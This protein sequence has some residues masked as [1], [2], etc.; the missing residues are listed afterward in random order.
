MSDSVARPAPDDGARG[1][2]LGRVDHLRLRELLG[3]GPLG[4]VYLAVDSVAD[5]LLAVKVLPAALSGESPEADRLR[6]A[7]LPAARFSHPRLAALRHLHTA[8]EADDGARALGVTRGLLLLLSDYI[9]GQD[10]ARWLQAH[11]ADAG[12]TTALMGWFAEAA[13]ALD[14]AHAHGLAHGALSP[15]NLRIGS[16]GHAHLTDLASSAELRRSLRHLGAPVP[17]A[18]AIGEPTPAGDVHDLARLLAGALAPVPAAGAERLPLAALDAA[19]NAALAGAL[20]ADPSRRPGSCRALVEACRAGLVPTAVA[21]VPAAPMAAPTADALPA[22]AP[23]PATAA[24][25]RPAVVSPPRVPSQ[26]RPT[27]SRSRRRGPRPVDVALGVAAV[28][29][30]SLAGL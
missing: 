8:W 22:A 4:S 10:L 27:V 30:L 15:G 9:E 20:S 7:L 19:G 29:L 1:R 18:P 24:G 11:A 12:R 14:A 13:E 21:G 16:D 28:L 2:D 3:H 26:H 25:A 6:Q 17:A 23:R 5:R